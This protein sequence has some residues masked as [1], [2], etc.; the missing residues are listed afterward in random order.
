MESLGRRD[1]GKEQHVNRP[2]A[3]AVTA[4]S[5]VTAG[6]LG[7]LLGM[8]VLESGC[9]KRGNGTG[10]LATEPV[11]RRDIALTVEATGT[12]EPINLVEV[13][14]KASGQIV[15]MPV[16]IGTLVHRGDLLVQVDPR[17]VQNAFDQ[18]QAALVAAEAR[19]EVARQQRRRAADLFAEQVITATE[20]EA[21]T[22]DDAN[23]QAQLVAARTNLDIARQRLEDATVRAP[24][25]GTVLEKPVA[26]GQVISSAT[27]SVSGGTTLLKMADL[28]RVRMRALVVETDIGRVR[29][30]QSVT[31][32][33]DAFP[34][35]PFHG[36]VEKI[37]PQAIVQQ[38]VT[39]FPVLVSV[40]NEGGLL[41]PGMNGEVTMMVDERSGVLAVPVDAI[42]GIRE[43]A[44][45]GPAFGF[46]L[47]SLRAQMAAMRGRT[48]PPGAPNGMEGGGR[49]GNAGP[50]PTSRASDARMGDR[51]PRGSEG[52][53]EAGAPDSATLAR[54]RARRGTGGDAAPGVARERMAGGRPGTTNPAG[55]AQG[56]GGPNAGVSNG[57]GRA[58]FA[59]V[60]TE[61][62]Y[63]PRLVRVG[64]SDY[65]Y[66]EI[67]SGL[68]EGDQVVMLG[69]VEMQQQREEMS[70]RV[71]QRF[72]S[73]VTSQGSTTQPAQGT[74]R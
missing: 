35:R 62:G 49:P 20:H 21:A 39:M 47:D 4:R 17:D 38:S 57:R 11:E 44:S 46:S 59:V 68:A 43:M 34:Q 70:N 67:L 41:L 74:R 53:G 30:G 36:V 27:S 2:W 51:G 66:A 7:V 29:E 73:G 64:L 26:V 25:S 61:G 71:R 1:N 16:E 28:T 8:T 14:S 22:L 12:V 3:V 37:E 13:K 10:I 32:L 48:G 69:V 40:E 65:D 24:I 5:M 31:V 18:A 50:V 45:I 19:S 15:Q 52:A 55:G 42:R 23:A 33:V 60:K 56:A 6:T 9:G 72:G 63:S 54:W 58:Q